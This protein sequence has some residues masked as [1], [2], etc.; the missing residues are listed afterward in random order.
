MHLYAHQQ[1][2]IDDDP[3]KYDLRLLSS[4]HGSIEE[5]ILINVIVGV[6]AVIN[7]DNRKLLFIENGGTSVLVVFLNGIRIIKG[8]V[9]KALNLNGKLLQI[10]NEICTQ[11]TLYMLKGTVKKIQPLI[12]LIPK[13]ITLN[14]IVVGPLLYNKVLIRRLVNFLLLTELLK[15]IQNGQRKLDVL[16]KHC[17]IVL[18]KASILN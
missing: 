4:C 18:T 5:C 2:I 1:K 8:T 13:G 6:F 3:Q 9:L 14:K 7:T 12:E 16:V 10:L 15:T 17:A 11:V